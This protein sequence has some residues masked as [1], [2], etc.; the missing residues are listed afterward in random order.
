MKYNSQTI[1]EISFAS[2]EVFRACSSLNVV[3]FGPNIK[4]AAVTD[5]GLPLRLPHGGTGSAFVLPWGNAD[6]FAL[7]PGAYGK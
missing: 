4:L 6:R 5:R 7:S 2:R 1:S 3:V